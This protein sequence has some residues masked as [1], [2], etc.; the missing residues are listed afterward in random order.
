[1]PLTK[2]SNKQ[3]HI[4]TDLLP[5]TDAATDLGSSSKQ[6]QDL[7]LKS[8]STIKFAGTNLTL[9]HSS[10]VLLLG[11]SQKLAFG[12][13]AEYISGDGTD[14]TIASSAKL[15]LTATS[16]VVMPSD[17]GLMLDGTSGQVK[18]EYVSADQNLIVKPGSSSNLMVGEN[19]W[20]GKLV[21]ASDNA[22]DLGRITAGTRE[23]ISSGSGPYNISPDDDGETVISNLSASTSSFYVKASEFTASTYSSGSKLTIGSWVGTLSGA[24]GA[25]NSD[26]YS[27]FSF[28]SASGTQAYFSSAFLQTADYVSSLEW[29]DLYIDGVAY[30]DE[31][32]LETDIIPETD[33]VSSIGGP[34][35]FG[36]FT[37]YPNINGN[38]TITASTT[39]LTVNSLGTSLAAEF[40]AG[41]YFKVLSSSTGDFVIFKVTSEP[42]SGAT[43]IACTMYSGSSTSVTV[44]SSFSTWSKTSTVREFK[45][46]WF[47][48]VVHVDTLEMSGIEIT[49]VLDEDDLSSDSAV[50]LATQ[51]SIKKYVDDSISASS[52]NIDDYDALGG[53]GLHQT[54][55][56]F[57]FSDNGTEKKITFSNLQDAVFADVSGDAT[58]AAGGALTIEAGAVENS[59]LAGSIA[60]SKLS[61]ISTAN[62]VSLS[63][64]DI[65]GATALGGASMDQ[66]D[67]LIIDD[68]AGGTNKSVTFSNFEDSIFGN[69]SGDATVAAGGVLTIA[70]DAVHASMI[71][72]DVAGSGLE[73]HSDGTLR[74]AAAAAGDGL[75]GGAGS[76]LALDLNELTAAD[77]AVASDSIAIIDA[78]DNSSKKE[79][80]ADLVTAMAGNGLAASSGVLAVGVDD[81]SIELNSDALRVKAS[82]V[83]NAMLAGSIANAKLTNSAVT[84]TA[85][86]GLSGGGSVSLG[87]SVSVALQVDDSSLEIDS[88]TARIKASGVTNA[89]LAGSISIDKI[90]ASDLTVKAETFGDLDDQIPT[91]AAVKQ[92]VDSVAEGLDVK[93]SVLCATTANITLSGNQT[94]DGVS[95]TAGKRILVKDQSTASQ[96]GIYVSSADSWSRADDMPTGD[97]A[98]GAFMFI[99]E[100]TSAA[101]TGWVCTSNAGS[102]VVG[103][104]NLA[105]SQFNGAGSITAGDGLGK[106]G[107]TLEVKVDDS[108]IEISS[109]SLRVKASGITNAMLGGSITNAKLA[110]SAVTVTAGDGLSGGGSVSLGGSVSVA[111][112]VDDSS[113]EID[114]DTARIKAS[115]VTN[116]ML[117]GS[118]A[119]SKLSTISTANKVSLAALDLDGG[120]DIGTAL[121]DADLIIVDDGAGGTNRKC[122][123]SRVATYASANLVASDVRGHLSAGSGGGLT[124]SGGAFSLSGWVTVRKAKSDF[125][126]SSKDLSFSSSGTPISNDSVMVFWNGML[127]D[128]SD[129][130]NDD[131]AVSGT[132]LTLSSTLYSEMESDDVITICFLKQ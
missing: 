121:A 21:P 130:S 97:A 78:D 15:N 105:F 127:L 106:T 89:M 96:N 128:S 104:N 36:S 26:G 34:A 107:N 35:G 94:I 69:I 68:G 108:S 79:S 52:V 3:L 18:I 55:D 91:T 117:A 88:D 92:Y 12:D 29:K 62:K 48:G 129:S 73:Q 4:H 45:N 17:V 11:G 20:S 72:S 86:D 38:Q 74:I 64:L 132:D 65:D 43:S 27:L 77:V 99:E 114:S 81:S 46:G 14:L 19:S 24:P 44:S 80:I 124:Y 61:T 85:G 123:M 84:V 56:H 41:S 70:A 54:E 39:S 122:A 7:Y 116:A 57:L 25:T 42:S 76:A 113:L 16:D 13:A 87:G 58:I 40:A 93:E 109:D 75:S 112:Q 2:I 83:T 5:V 50:A 111:L 115:G 32:Q 98:A 53:A 1:M 120:T 9:T 125:D 6:W 28:S 110:N 49:S 66:A 101:D 126:S 37:G 8:G 71:N 10:G 103:T 33:D 119:D 51:Q 67:L 82:G 63:A 102:D 100:G 22:A 60:D 118:I 31:I 47:D 95:V 131:C 59:M 90:L 23:T 30:L